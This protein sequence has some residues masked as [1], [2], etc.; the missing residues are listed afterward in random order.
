MECSVGWV[1]SRDGWKQAA[2][3]RV[4]LEERRKADLTDLGQ[5]VALQEELDWECYRLYGVDVGSKARKPD[6]VQPTPPNWRPV[7]LNLAVRDRE[8]RAAIERGDETTEIPTVWFERHRWEP[9]TELPSD[10]PKA[11][12]EL[13]AA[14]RARIEATP[15]LSLIEQ[16]TYK[17]RW[18]RPD[19]E[20]EEQAALA[21]WLT[22]QI[23]RTLSERGG[24]PCT[25]TQLTTALENDPR[26]QAVA[27]LLAGRKDYRLTEL[28]ADA[29]GADVRPRSS[30]PRLQAD[31]PRQACGVGT[32]V[33]G[34]AQG[35]RRAAGE[36]RGAA[37]VRPG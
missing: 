9:L 18:Y 6:E 24:R 11:L 28:V 22:D 25:L 2:D 8:T 13:V 7:E 4:L 35:G 34:A 29:V 31:R 23:E 20:T 3:L 26:V 10:A 15:E 27:E 30:V 19:Y 36:A 1:L 17:R 21:S 16:T 14:R 5:M 12:R 32:D 37:E 33:G